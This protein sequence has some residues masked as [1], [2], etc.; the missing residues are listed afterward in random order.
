[1]DRTWRKARSAIDQTIRTLQRGLHLDKSKFI[2]SKNS[3]VPL[4]YYFATQSS[5]GSGGRNPLRFFILS[6]LSEHYSAAAE[7]ALRKDFRILADPSMTKKQRLAEL[8]GVVDKDARQNYRG[9]KIRPDHVSGLPS[10]NVL[11][12]LIYIL[13]RERRATDWGSGRP[14]PL[15]EIEPRDL[16]LHHIFPFNLMVN[17]RS[18][19]KWYDENGYTP[20]DFRREV[21][22]I[23]NLTPISQAK[24]AAIGDAPPWQ[25]LPNETTKE[26]RRAHFIPEIP[27]LWKP[28]NYRD[29]LDERRK[30]LSTAMTR[31]L[32][33]L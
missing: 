5:R 6:Q 15:A 27:E 10:K 28:E 20:A 16:Q 1:M 17:S 3:M 7:T 31:F 8:V 13:M 2:T 29:F 4:V 32:K 12:L 25:Y 22:D 33:K 23:A 9:L 19:R 11:V 24:N 26:M 21:N 18:A 14:K 30:L